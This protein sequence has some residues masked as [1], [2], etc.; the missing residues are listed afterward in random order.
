VASCGEAIE[1]KALSQPTGFFCA[2]EIE[3]G[4]GARDIACIGRRPPLI[5][6][7]EICGFG[8]RP[9]V[10]QSDGYEIT[11]IEPTAITTAAHFDLLRI[12]CFLHIPSE[13]SPAKLAGLLR[14]PFEQS[15][16]YCQAIHKLILLFGLK[17]EQ[18]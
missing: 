16:I 18:V 12:A 5:A 13:R 10:L 7:F 3:D 4:C 9:I 2:R 11:R 1:L 14:V 15:A 8:L 6:R 17:K